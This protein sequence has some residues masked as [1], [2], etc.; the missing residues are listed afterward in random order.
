MREKLLVFQSG[1]IALLGLL[2]IY[3][4]VKEKYI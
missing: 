3:K 1:I 4:E 2:I